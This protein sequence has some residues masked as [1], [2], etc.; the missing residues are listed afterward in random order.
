MN[1]YKHIVQCHFQLLSNRPTFP[2]ILQVTPVLESKILGL[3]Q[4][5]LVEVLP[6][7][8][9]IDPEIDRVELND[10]LMAIF[11]RLD[12]ST[13]LLAT[14]STRVKS[15]RLDRLHRLV[16]LIFPAGSLAEGVLPKQV[17]RL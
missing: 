11:D 10:R 2:E 15:D 6:A 8:Q 7:I 16:G 3:S 1:S 4:Q 13:R 9:S 17:V 5:D 14:L 12:R